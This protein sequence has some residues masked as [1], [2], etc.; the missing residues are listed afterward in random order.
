LYAL[1]L[2][3]G[4]HFTNTAATYGLSTALHKYGCLVGTI[5]VV[6]YIIFNPFS[7]LHFLVKT[8]QKVSSFY[9]KSH[10]YQKIITQCL[11]SR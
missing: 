11:L 5:N 9:R 1:L 8:V 2:L 7:D 4:S 3:N 6:M 10:R